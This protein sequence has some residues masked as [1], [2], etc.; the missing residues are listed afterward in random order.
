MEAPAQLRSV[1]DEQEDVT[2]ARRDYDSEQVIAIDF[3][4]G[5]DATLDIVGDTAIVIAGDQQYEFD[6]PPES[7]EMTTND[8][9]LVLTERKE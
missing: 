5:V 9:I 4:P 7:V 1:A 6:R 8:G 2:F 3:G